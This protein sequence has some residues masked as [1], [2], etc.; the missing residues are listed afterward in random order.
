M[1]HRGAFGGSFGGWLN[2]RAAL[3]IRVVLV[4]TNGDV[5]RAARALGISRFTLYRILARDEKRIL[6]LIAA[7]TNP[8]GERGGE[9]G[10]DDGGEVGGV[11]AVV[12][13][14][15]GGGAEDDRQGAV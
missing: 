9:H 7:R 2:R 11:G 5:Q 8:L 10:G 1:S 6:A 14:A 4:H 13:G 3:R 15:G 12:G